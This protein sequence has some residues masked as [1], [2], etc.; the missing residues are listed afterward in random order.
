MKNIWRKLLNLLRR[1]WEQ[2]K[3]WHNLVIF[4]I[5]AVLLSG[6]VWIPALLGLITGNAAMYA[7][8]GA[9]WAVWLGPL[10]FFPI[11]IL[12]TVWIRAFLKKIK[13][14]GKNFD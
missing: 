4:L 8:A 3:D 12:L 10:P 7:V 5:V 1:L 14:K 2:L 11:C 9:V 6:T 13:K